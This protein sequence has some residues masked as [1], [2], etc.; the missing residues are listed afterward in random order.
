MKGKHIMKKPSLI[1]HGIANMVMHL[2]VLLLTSFWSLILLG[3]QTDLSNKYP[4]FSFFN[5]QNDFWMV[6]MILPLCIP[7]ISCIWGIIR[8]ALNFKKEKE[9]KICLILSVIG[10]ILYVGM[11]ALCG[12][13]GSRF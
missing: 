10:L 3:I 6:V 11:M 5:H 2:P 13:L 4:E 9:A 12:Y 8:G 7:P 1:F